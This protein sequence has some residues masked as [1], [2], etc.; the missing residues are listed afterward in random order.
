MSPH[1]ECLLYWPH[2]HFLGRHFPSQSRILNSFGP[3]K[4]HTGKGTRPMSEDEDLSLLPAIRAALS[5]CPTF[6]PEM[7]T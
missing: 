3:E 6:I 1:S 5:F 7:R 4:V 2:T